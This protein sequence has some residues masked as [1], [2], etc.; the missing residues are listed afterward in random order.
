MGGQ[1]VGEKA[2]VEFRSPK[3]KFRMRGAMLGPECVVHGCS[4][5]WDH[6]YEV[7]TI[8]A[9]EQRQLDDVK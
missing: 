2:A 4:L 1:R 8:A 3:R 7:C 6:D 9:R 5:S